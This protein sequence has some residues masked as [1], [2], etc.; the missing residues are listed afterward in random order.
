MTRFLKKSLL[1]AV[2]GLGALTATMPAASA[3]NI[4]L[5]IEQAGYR[6]GFFEIRD[7][8]GRRDRWDRRHDRRQGNWGGR[9]RCDPRLAM[10]KAHDFGLRRARIADVTPRKVVVEGFRYQG[11]GRIVFANDRHCPVLWR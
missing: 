3:A 6:N 11:Y 8:D 9:G 1:A 4:E 10:V 7:H 5:S 2:L